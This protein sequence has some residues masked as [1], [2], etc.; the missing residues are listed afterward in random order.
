LSL[1]AAAPV[2]RAELGSDLQEV[3]DRIEALRGEVGGVRAQRTDI[4][5]QVLDTADR[6]E[7]AAAEL[8]AAESAFGETE[9]LISSTEARLDELE[10]SV[11]SR[12]LRVERLRDN[13]AATKLLARDRAVELYMSAGTE[14]GLIAVRVEDVARLALGL[15]YADRLQES[16]DRDIARLAGLQAQEGREIAGLEAERVD[17]D[18]QVRVLE[19]QR[20]ERRA[21]ADAVAART[22]E[23]EAE[24]EV[25]RGQLARLDAEVWHIENEIAVLAREEEWIKELIRLEQFGDGTSPGELFR[26][27]PGGVSSGFGYRIHPIYGDSRLHTGWDMDAS[28]NQP[29]RAA[30]EGRVIYSGWRGGYGNAIII[31]HGG[32]LATLYAHHNSL[33]VG[34]GAPVATGD[35]IGLAGSTGLSTTCHLHFEVRV[36]GEPVDP[37]PY[38]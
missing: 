33:N 18:E 14:G 16:A 2:A 9:S 31:D 24:L 6:L 1:V 19:L 36:N 10:S 34:Y 28:C 15:A 23:V 35:I 22:V 4:A 30:G 26:P 32:G 7:A 3:A 25:Q 8:A 5:N 12:E 27:V 17:L 38:L 37:T 29:I 21:A 20:E 11:A 13:I